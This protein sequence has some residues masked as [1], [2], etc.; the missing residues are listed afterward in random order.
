MLVTPSRVRG[1]PTQSSEVFPEY[2]T[3]CPGAVAP[4]QLVRLFEHGVGLLAF[5]FQSHYDLLE[6]RSHRHLLVQDN[7]QVPSLIGC[8]NVVRRQKH[9]EVP[10]T[11][12]F[13]LQK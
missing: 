5:G 12:R 3:R 9:F 8:Q 10:L 13:P 11:L 6:L 7:P 4:T 2:R 1:K